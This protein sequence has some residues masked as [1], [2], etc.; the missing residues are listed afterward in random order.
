MSNPSSSKKTIEDLKPTDFIS[1]S[2]IE[3]ARSRYTTEVAQSRF[4]DWI[5]RLSEIPVNC[6]H[7]D[8]LTTGHGKACP[9]NYNKPAD[10]AN[11]GKPEVVYSPPKTDTCSVLTGGS[12]ITT[13]PNSGTNTELSDGQ[14]ECVLLSPM[15][16]RHFLGIPGFPRAPPTWWGAFVIRPVRGKGLGMIASRDIQFGEMVFCERPLLMTW[17]PPARRGKVGSDNRIKISDEAREKGV[18]NA[19][20]HGYLIQQALGRMNE[21]TREQFFALEDEFVDGCEKGTP[22][23]IVASN[24]LIVFNSREHPEVPY[25]GVF[26]DLS[27]INHSCSPN[28][29]TMWNPASFSILS[30][31]LRPIAKGEEITRSYF[32]VTLPYPSRKDALAGRK[33]SCACKAC[34]DPFSFVTKL[35]NV[36]P[37]FAS[38]LKWAST[39]SLR[40][41][42]DLLVVPALELLKLIEDEGQ[43]EHPAYRVVLENLAYIHY[44]LGMKD[45]VQFFATKKLKLDE[46]L[47]RRASSLDELT[48]GFATLSQ[49]MGQA[50]VERPLVKSVEAE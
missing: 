41:R 6:F 11:P 8:R 33:F 24:G 37:A 14:S 4:D 47:G 23:G 28:I 13:L 17:V 19:F 7:T 50:G 34:T 12:L 20:L 31:A 25:S 22:R 1:L 15:D 3:N 10:T 48:K 44:V 18:E 38:I 26:K 45:K 27:R 16:K 9:P 40:A 29:T 49:A 46:I 39:P 30:Y 35:N 21:R 5:D 2:Q 43:Q 36:K 32:P 42:E